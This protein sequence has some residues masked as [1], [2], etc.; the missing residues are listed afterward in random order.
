MRTID[1]ILDLLDAHE[2]ALTA[3]VN[4]AGIN[5]PLHECTAQDFSSFVDTGIDINKIQDKI[6]EAKKF[7]STPYKSTNN[8]PDA[9]RDFLFRHQ[10]DYITRFLNQRFGGLFFDTGTGKTLTILEMI[11][12]RLKAGQTVLYICPKNVFST[13]AEQ[14]EEY[15][16]DF[17]YTIVTGNE[18]HKLIELERT[19]HLHIV[20]YESL[21]N[22]KIWN[23]ILEKKFTVCILD[24]CHKI[25][26][27]KNKITKRLL[28]NAH[29]FQSRWVMSGT[30]FD[31]PQDVYSVISFLDLYS[32]FGRSYWRFLES[33][34]RKDWSGFKRE[35]IPEM[36]PKLQ[37]AISSMS[38]TVKIE[39]CLDMPE[40]T[41]QRIDVILKGSDA[42]AYIDMLK[43]SV[44]VF[45]QADITSVHKVTQINY[46]RQI[47][48]GS[49]ILKNEQGKKIGNQP[50][51]Q[52]K[53]QVL[54]D[55]IKEHNNR[56]VIVC[57]FIQEIFEIRE[58]IEELGHSCGVICGRIKP[59]ERNHYRLKFSAG[60]L[61]FLILQSAAG[62]GIDGLQNNCNHMYFFS[63]SYSYKD[64]YQIEARLFRSG[65]KNNLLIVDFVAAI[66]DRKTG[67][68]KPTID[69]EILHNLDNK[70]ET[71]H[72]L[73]KNTIKN[74]K[75]CYE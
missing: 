31:K 27:H 14:I 42:T 32:S 61:D 47:T 22:D 29:I 67:Q 17:C 48:G 66:E 39:N 21:L 18:K 9:I 58:K 59:D 5:K 35:L 56:A 64:N 19:R 57:S 24:E 73:I 38:Q 63:R 37:S 23:R 41:Y 50:L 45:E 46:L 62:V 65:L 13:I 49:I 68:L 44:L 34:T 25:G 51:A 10:K 43:K 75:E 6:S 54:M 11:R 16:P 7:I 4:F 15:T 53:I 3:K 26:N 20:N 8:S 28:K 40:K 71:A 52:T 30:P 12:I 55:Y 36:K 60:E 2:T 69:S 70:K 1:T 74:Y 33:Y 72:D